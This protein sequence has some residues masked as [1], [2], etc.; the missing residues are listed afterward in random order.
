MST[1]KNRRAYP[2]ALKKAVVASVKSGVSINK[3]A[4]SFNVSGPSTSLWAAKAGVSPAIAQPAGLAAHC[5]KL[6]ANKLFNTPTVVRGGIMYKG[7][8]YKK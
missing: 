8:L 6:K 4:E 1:I 5:A 2:V 3:T 7:K